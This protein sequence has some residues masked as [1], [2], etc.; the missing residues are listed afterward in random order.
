MEDRYVDVFDVQLWDAEL[1]ALDALRR[2]LRPGEPSGSPIE[3]AVATVSEF[4]VKAAFL[5][6]SGLL[7]QGAEGD[8]REVMRSF[9]SRLG[10][11]ET[12]QVV[13][14]RELGLVFWLRQAAWPPSVSDAL[15]G[16]LA[17]LG[18]DDGIHRRVVDTYLSTA[19]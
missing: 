14:A 8:S 5:L 15:T 10:D 2:D 13:A 9:E 3:A 19:G 4:E 18:L 16:W 6:W 1:E 12:P 11:D 7:R 17:T